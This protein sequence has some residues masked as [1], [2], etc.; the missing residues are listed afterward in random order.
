MADYMATHPYTPC[1][2]VVIGPIDF[3]QIALGVLRQTGAPVELPPTS[4]GQA[5]LIVPA[6][7]PV[8]LLLQALHYHPEFWDNP[9]QFMPERW[10]QGEY[11][12]V[13]VTAVKLTLLRSADLSALHTTSDPG[14]HTETNNAFVPFLDG[15]RQCQ[16]RFLA[17]LEFVTVLQ[18][19][20]RTHV[21]H[22]EA[23][24]S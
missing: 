24:R 11:R 19:R 17:E 1:V 5:P 14:R 21:S 2:E 12:S 10:A 18:V 6:D 8:V 16:G 9:Q 13:L 3:A 15:K 22:Q 4:P 20:F 7:T 23:Q